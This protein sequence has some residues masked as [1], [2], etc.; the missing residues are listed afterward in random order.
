MTGY[1]ARNQA[2]LQKGQAKV[3]LLVLRDQSSVFSNGNGNTFQ[4]LLDNGYSYNLTSEGVIKLNEVSVTNG[5]I[6]EDGPAY[7]ALIF[8][9]VSNI[10][11]PAM[12]KILSM[13]QAGLPVIIYG[14]SV[15]ATVYGT[16]STGNSTAAMLS[17]YSQLTALSN[18]Y[19]AANQNALLDILT[20]INVTPA[21]S[22][23][24][25]R[26]QASRYVDKAT[27]TNY[28]YMFND[29]RNG[30]SGMLN[31]NNTPN[32]TWKS[33]AATVGIV[34]LTGDGVPCLLD[35]WTGEI[36][37]E[38]AYTDNGDG[39]VSFK[40]SLSGGESRL[41]AVLPLTEALTSV[42]AVSGGAEIVRTGS[43]L[44]LRANAPGTYQVTQTDDITIPVFVDSVPA[45]VSLTSG[46]S[47]VLESWGPDISDANK[48][49]P[50]AGIPYNPNYLTYNRSSFDASGK[51][52][53]DGIWKDPSA[54]VKTKIDFNNIQLMNWANLPASAQQLQTIGVSSMANVSGI[55]YYSNTF[56]LSADW[57]NAGAILNMSYGRDSVTQVTVN[58]HVFNNIN[59][60]TDKLDIG[61]YLLAGQENT[62][63]IKLAST[64]FNRARLTNMS[65]MRATGTQA[66]LTANGLT[67]VSLAPYAQVAFRLRVLAD[68]R[69]DDANVVVNN[70]VSYTVSLD[71]AKGVGA[72]D[73]DF[74]FDGYV[75]DKNSITA[76]PLNGFA[77]G[78]NPGL[79]FEYIGAGFWK[80]SVSYMHILADKFVG[81]D[82]PLDVVKISGTAIDTGPATVTI[83]NFL[84]SG[85][86]GKGV[87]PM[88]SAIK[89]DEA[90]T[91]IGSK[92]AVY[93]KYDLNK[94]GSIDET[95]LLYLIY[96]YQW[97][98]RDPGWGTDD[99]YGIFAKDCD[100]QVN[101]R[102]DLADM[103]ELIANYG[104]Y[105]PYA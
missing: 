92:P 73:L 72:F 89:T 97:T 1:F 79:T 62:I 26:L 7:K 48:Q 86:T 39:T 27:G 80:G 65:D 29:A 77:L 101:G 66:N 38:T 35:A 75:L 85:D 100:F 31:N 44:A 51:T 60:V 82:G 15:P 2:V 4:T 8:N 70:P 19:T 74:I 52:G 5:V 22:Y 95:D 93:S 90:T 50:I 102:I 96:F 37:P 32:A 3:D 40:V 25:A 87:G 6:C 59:N 10:S 84:A 14:A 105:D 61:D 98:D 28:Y 88:L 56:T 24:V 58:G 34:T 41:Y 83:T 33:G 67:S 47:L 99:L 53:Y 71:S 57:K 9:G 104:K 68:I 78:A 76:T 12:L 54:T 81:V 13:A 42:E 49:D 11:A 36:K 46:W 64:L 16:D 91:T 23:N 17:L 20:G 94:D 63:K 18:V 43:E 45:P 30:A 103:I 69:A 21:A 55:G